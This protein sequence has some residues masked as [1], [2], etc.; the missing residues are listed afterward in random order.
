MAR[1]VLCAQ[2]CLV[3]LDQPRLGPGLV[4]QQ[5]ERVQL[6]IDGLDDRGLA[7][8]DPL[9]PRLAGLR[10]EGVGGV[11]YRDDVAGPE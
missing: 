6:G 8:L 9:G 2:P 3:D 7:I 10:V 5:G 1:G 11:P 4:Q